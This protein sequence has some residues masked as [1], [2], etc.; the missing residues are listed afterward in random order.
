MSKLLISIVSDQTIPNIIFIKEFSGFDSYYFITT[1][2]M[3]NKGKCDS[4]I[5]SSHLDENICKKIVVIED[6]IED[7][8][9]RLKNEFEFQD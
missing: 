3:E 4:I 5:K 9:K 1:K 6:D 2:A 7:V 8:I